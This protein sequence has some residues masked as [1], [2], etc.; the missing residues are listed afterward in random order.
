MH[1]TAK[2]QLDDPVARAKAKLA[3]VSQYDENLFFKSKL[4]FFESDIIENEK[5]RTKLVRNIKSQKEANDK[6]RLVLNMFFLSSVSRLCS[7][8]VCNLR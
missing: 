1:T 7:V 4:Q 3:Q 5:G 8:L 6:V 2:Q